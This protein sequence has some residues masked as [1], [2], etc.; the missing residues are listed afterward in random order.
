[1]FITE[2]SRNW[3]NFHLSREVMGKKKAE[4]RDPDFFTA[5]SPPTTLSSNMNPRAGEGR[6]HNHADPVSG[7]V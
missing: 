1:M 6:N 2:T 4:P 3:S 5:R 7:I